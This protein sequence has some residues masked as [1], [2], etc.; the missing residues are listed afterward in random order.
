[1]A[2]IDIS[3]SLENLKLERDAIELYDALSGIEKDPVR[4]AA[5]RRIAANE[6]RHAD[7][8][9]RKLTELGATVPAVDRPRARVRFIILAARLFGTHSVAELDKALE[10]DV[11]ELY[12]AYKRSLTRAE[13]EGPWYFRLKTV[14]GLQ[15]R[16]LLDYDLR[17]TAG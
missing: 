13:W 17:R 2:P 8:W 3:T 9:A 7:I 4:A 16:G 14:K 5:F 6:R 11:E 12:E 10:G 15:E 1:M